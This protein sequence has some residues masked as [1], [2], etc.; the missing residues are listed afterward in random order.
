MFCSN[1]GQK[2][3]DD[4]VVC[5]WCGASVDVD[6]EPQEAPQASEFTQQ[7]YGQQQSYM[8][9]KRPRAGMAVKP[10]NVSEKTTLGIAACLLGAIAFWSGMFSEL[11]AC[12]LCAYILIKEKDEWLRR[13]AAKAAL[14]AIA[15]AAVGGCISVLQNI[16]GSFNSL[17]SVLGNYGIGGPVMY[18]IFAITGNVISIIKVVL[19][20]L[21]GL[22]TLQYKNFNIGPLDSFIS[23]HMSGK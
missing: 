23:K 9:H 7:P 21:G 3:D 8:Q 11:T 6:D 4:A 5:K 17:M 19:L 12:L 20:L 15:A 16:F 22:Q 14:I 13:A 1:C 10:D 18:Q 2:I